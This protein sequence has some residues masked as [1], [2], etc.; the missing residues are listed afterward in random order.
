MKIKRLKNISILQGYKLIN[1]PLKLMYV[2]KSHTRSS[3]PDQSQKH[4]DWIIILSIAIIPFW[5]NFNRVDYQQNSSKGD[6]GKD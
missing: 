6:Y 2:Y 1:F 4:V 5:N 3:S